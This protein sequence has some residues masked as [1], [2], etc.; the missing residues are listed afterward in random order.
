MVLTG[1]TVRFVNHSDVMNRWFDVCAFRVG[2][3]ES[4][5]FAILFTNITD[6]KGTELALQRSDTKFR[7]V[8]DQMYQFLGLLTP[9]GQM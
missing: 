2:G 9:D 3:Q 6:R 7:A 5:T 8:F 1:E 4:Q